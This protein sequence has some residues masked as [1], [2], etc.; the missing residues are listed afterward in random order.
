MSATESTH[1]AALAGR[2]ANGYERDGGSVVHA[3]T[4]DGLQRALC[5]REPGRRSVGW[6]DRPMEQVTCARCLNKL[7]KRTG[8]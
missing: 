1:P 8:S 3:V 4:N 7:T 5:G 6:S 2:C